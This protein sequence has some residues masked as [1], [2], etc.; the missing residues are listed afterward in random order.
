MMLN[1]KPTQDKKKENRKQTE[2]ALFFQ[3]ESWSLILSA[4]FQCFIH[5]IL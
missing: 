4:A 5:V 2:N 3:R 1:C